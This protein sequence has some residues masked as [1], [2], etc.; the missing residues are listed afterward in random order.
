MII[1]LQFFNFFNRDLAEDNEEVH[2]IYWECEQMCR[3]ET[4]RFGYFVVFHTSTFTIVL[5][6]ALICIVFGHYD[7]SSWYLSFFLVLPF[8]QTYVFGWLLTWLTQFDI[9]FCY[10]LCMTSITSYMVSCCNYINA[11]CDHFNVLVNNVAEDVQRLKMEDNPKKID[12]IRR[13][14][15]AQQCNIVIFFIK[16]YE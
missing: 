7:T 1:F 9:A 4:R 13:E 10:A 2:T 12:E 11:M 3:K 15:N 5:T 6:Y 14:I 16:I 8:K